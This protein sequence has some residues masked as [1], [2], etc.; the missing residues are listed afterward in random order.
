MLIKPATQCFSF[1]TTWCKTC[2]LPG[3]RLAQ[4]AGTLSQASS[5]PPE[6]RAPTKALT[7][8][9]YKDPEQWVGSGNGLV[10]VIVVVYG[11]QVPVDVCVA[12]QHVNVGDLVNVLQQSIK[13][14][15]LPGLGSFQ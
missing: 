12:H 5:P 6:V 15:K 1:C 3:V 7:L 2:T 8:L 9:L 14:L 13:L 11:Q 10:V 4:E